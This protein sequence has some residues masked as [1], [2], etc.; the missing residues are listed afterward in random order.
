MQSSVCLSLSLS[1][2][3]CR[4]LCLTHFHISVSSLSLWSHTWGAAD[5]VSLTSCILFTNSLPSS[6]SA[7]VSRLPP[8]TVAYFV[9]QKE[10]ADWVSLLLHRL[11]SVYLSPPQGPGLRRQ[12]V[13]LLRASSV[14]SRSQATKYSWKY[15]IFEVIL[16]AHS[17]KPSYR[18]ASETVWS[19]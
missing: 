11:A 6:Q 12:G 19:D 13:R 2:S 15:V 5:W 8:P 16:K 3:V 1:H 18:C 14:Q 17:S 7:L 9:N 10:G 4:Y